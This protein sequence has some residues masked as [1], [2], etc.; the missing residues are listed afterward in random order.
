MILAYGGMAPKTIHCPKTE[1]NLVGK[2][3]SRETL[4]L[5]LNAL[6]Q[7]IGLLGKKKKQTNKQ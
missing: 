6:Q 1:Q 2:I 7:E 3:F 4:Q 5:G